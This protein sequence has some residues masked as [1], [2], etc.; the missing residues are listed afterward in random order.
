MH[1]GSY[2]RIE[3]HVIDTYKKGKPLRHMQWL[4]LNHDEQL[5]EAIENYTRITCENNP[6]LAIYIL[7]RYLTLYWVD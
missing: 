4:W 2:S 5:E 6:S 3:E 1:I 7:V